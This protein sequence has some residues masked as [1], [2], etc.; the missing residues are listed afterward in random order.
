MTRNRL[1]LWIGLMLLVLIVLSSPRSQAQA[2]EN[3]V[4]EY[5][6]SLSRFL[7][8]NPS[9]LNEIARKTSL[10]RQSYLER[11]VFQ[12]G[13]SYRRSLNL[14]SLPDSLI[15]SG[16]N[17]RGRI[18][19]VEKIYFDEG[20]PNHY[21]IGM[22][23]HELSHAEQEHMIEVSQTPFDRIL[24][25]VLVDEIRP[26]LK[27]N[28][29]ELSNRRVTI[30]YNEIF[31][32]YRHEAIQQML[33]LRHEILAR[34]GLILV[35]R[36]PRCSFVPRIKNRMKQ[37]PNPADLNELAGSDLLG[38]IEKRILV[39]GVFVMG[40]EVDLNKPKFSSFQPEWTQAMWSHLVA[41]HGVPRTGEQ[42]AS[43]VWRDKIVR[44]QVEACWEQARVQR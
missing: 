39:T 8:L 41:A 1:G 5:S 18:K 42:L 37:G 9:R 40:H 32:Y 7:G 43:W 27:R 21:K 22:I 24:L 28:Y 19:S 20:T 3:Y 14:I 13:A 44:Q 17:G 38:P 23:F 30:A 35:D 2:E 4:S 10:A 34:N 33:E 6:R 25:N 11:E 12:A 36:N 26:W 29:P 15:E 31:G 16:P